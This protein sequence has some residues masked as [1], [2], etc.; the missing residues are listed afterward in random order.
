MSLVLVPVDCYSFS[1]NVYLISIVLTF[2]P[3]VTYN[4]RCRHLDSV[5][6]STCLCIVWI[7]TA[8]PTFLEVL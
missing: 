1:G 6:L 3:M 8:T 4:I 5:N 7:Y 2:Y